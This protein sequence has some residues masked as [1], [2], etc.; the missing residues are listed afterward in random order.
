MSDI[1]AVNTAH[2]HA[3]A[4]AVLEVRDIPGVRTIA[5]SD[6]MEEWQRVRTQVLSATAATTVMGTNPFS[7]VMD[8]WRERMEGKRPT[9]SQFSIT[10]M[11]YGTVA[12]P[13]LLEE[14]NAHVHPEPNF[15]L[16]HG[17]VVWEEDQ[18]F[19]ATPD[20]WRLVDDMLELAEFKTG[21]KNRGARHPGASRSCHR[22]TT[23]RHSGRCL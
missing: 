4:R 9:F 6:N 15:V 2:E 12:E 14:A 16:T 10:V 5:H 1:R 20:A 18:R 22:T 11:N 7:T 3:E 17:F 19:G 23:T 21:S 13:E 8:L